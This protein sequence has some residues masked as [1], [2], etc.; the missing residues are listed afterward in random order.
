MGRHLRRSLAKGA[1]WFA[2]CAVALV[3][4]ELYMMHPDLFF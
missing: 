4:R 1:A 2:L 3:T